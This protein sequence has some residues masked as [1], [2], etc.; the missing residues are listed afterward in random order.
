MMCRSASSK[1]YEMIDL[2]QLAPPPGLRR[3]P[4]ARSGLDPERTLYPHLPPTYSAGPS[5]CSQ[6]ITPSSPNF[7]NLPRL[8][9]PVNVDFCNDTH[10]AV[11][12]RKLAER[13]R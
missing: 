3:Q 9:A 6:G 1:R 11:I 4:D 5:F 2:R 10:R 8:N 12:R 13:R 7:P